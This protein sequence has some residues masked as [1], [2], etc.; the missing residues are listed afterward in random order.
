MPVSRE[1]HAELE[2]ARYRQRRAGGG[3]G[4]GHLVGLR[5]HRGDVV[6]QR[7]KV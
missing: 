4:L 5:R 7:R 1:R 2:L 6:S 3:D